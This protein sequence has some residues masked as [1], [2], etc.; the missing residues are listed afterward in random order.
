MHFLHNNDDNYDDDLVCLIDECGGSIRARWMSLR[1][2]N[3]KK[4]SRWL[5]GGY[6]VGWLGDHLTDCRLCWT[7][8]SNGNIAKVWTSAPSLF[9][10]QLLL[11]FLTFWNEKCLSPLK[12]N[13][14]LSVSLKGRECG[15]DLF[16]DES[17]PRLLRFTQHLKC[18]QEM[19]H[20]FFM[21]WMHLKC[22]QWIR[23]TDSWNAIA[24]ACF[25]D[26]EWAANRGYRTVGTPT[27][28][29]INYKKQIAFFWIIISQAQGILA[30][31]TMSQLPRPI[32]S[33][34]F[35]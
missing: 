31:L 4:K 32:D 26:V 30:F 34:G 24:N 18:M 6:G 9:P 3:R 20:R 22:M 16:F 8:R 28:R 27:T 14:S 12:L 7:L 11:P 15:P 29:M 23:L 13:L 2:L 5:H 33:S 19:H 21:L 17:F 10:K 1:I 25:G 35:L